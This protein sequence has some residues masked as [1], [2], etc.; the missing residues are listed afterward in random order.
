MRGLSRRFGLDGNYSGLAVA[1]IGG[2]FDLFTNALVDGKALTEAELASLQDETK[3]GALLSM[4]A[5]ALGLA[6]ARLLRV[7]R[8]GV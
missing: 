5:F 6:A 3:L 1:V 2:I 7:G 8:F 4:S